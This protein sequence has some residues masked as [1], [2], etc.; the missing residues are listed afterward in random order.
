MIESDISSDGGSSALIG[1][2]RHA[3]MSVD[4]GKADLAPGYVEVSV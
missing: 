3:G 4:G 1:R 2:A